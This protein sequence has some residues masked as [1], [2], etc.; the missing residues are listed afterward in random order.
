MRSTTESGN[1]SI[2]S[3]VMEASAAQGLS[4]GPE[5]AEDRS[6]NPSDHDA[7]KG[8]VDGSIGSTGPEPRAGGQVIQSK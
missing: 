5:E 1:S 8:R 4:L 6:S 3:G 7:G 2:E